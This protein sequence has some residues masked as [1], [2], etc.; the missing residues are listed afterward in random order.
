MPT[1]S[2]MDA[3][4]MA[5]LMNNRNSD[6][7]G[8][9]GG[10]FMMGALMGRLLFNN[11]MDGNNNNRNWDN[12]NSDRAAI[13]SAVSAALAQNNQ[14]NNNAMLLL[15]DIQDSSQEV[16]SSIQ[17]AS[18]AGITAT[19]NA[20]IANLQGQGQISTAIADAKYTTV[21]EVHESATDVIASNT[22]NTAQ[23]AATM[24]A[25]GASLAQGHADINSAIQQAKYDN[26]LVTMNDGEKTRAAIALLASQIPNSRELDLQR[27]LTVALDDHRHTQTRGIIDSGNTTVTNN[28]NMNQQQQQ[29]QQQLLREIDILRREMQ[30]N[31][32]STIAIGSTM[33]GNSQTA[34]NVRQ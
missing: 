4:T 7:L 21:N 1:S 14:A 18:N 15:K 8:M 33:M 11:G 20:E 26:A 5:A 13:E 24:N 2:G 29:Q 3:G 17:A 19:M 30:V 31:T 34:T 6:G 22:A 32:Q 28:I 25:L 27:Q 16:I 23:L 10:G 9:G 12:Q